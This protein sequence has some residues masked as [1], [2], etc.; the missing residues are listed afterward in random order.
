[1]TTPEGPAPGVGSPLG[2]P[3]DGSDPLDV[4]DSTTAG[5]RVIR[6]GILR[7]TTYAVGISIGIASAAL[8]TRYLG[9][10]DFGRY[11]IVTSLISIV[12]GLTEAGIP[13]VAAREFATRAPGDRDQ[14]FANVL[15]IRL[16]VAFAGVAAAIA[17]AIAAGYDRTMVAGTLLAGI[18]LLIATV[19]QTYAIPIGVSLRFGWLSSLDL[20]RQ[21]AFVAIIVVL[22]VASAGLLP[23]F[24]ATIPTSLLLLALMIPLVRGT[25]PLLP[26]F[27]RAEWVR[28]LRLVG[29][30]A[31]AAAVGTIYVSAVIVTT[32]LVGTAE[33]SGYLGAAFRV[34]SVLGAI[35]LLLI[36][37]AFPVLARAA[38]NDPE[39]LQYA[40]QRLIDI[41]LIVGS[42][43]ALSTVLGAGVAI[44][45]V[46]GEDFRSAV[47]VLQIL[48]AALLTTFLAVT[49]GLS[50]VSLRRHVALLVGNLVAL[51][52]SVA[53]TAAL[54]PEFGAKGAAVAT[55]VAD[56][57]IVVL[58][59]LVL[60]RV[61]SVRYDLELVPRVAIAAA[62]SGAVV[63]T[64]LDGVGLV[65]A[66]TV[67]YWGV[68]FAVR[69]VPSEVIDALL[70]REPRQTR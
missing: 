69:G 12:A 54:V 59:G 67:I 42:W 27:D 58:Y 34:F 15:G 21:I 22:V 35:P 41:S 11:V 26:R 47:P 64:P 4:L 18:G 65:L 62:L 61:R 36:S 10:E 37:T 16:A 50:L 33:E 57:G 56:C 70:R 1:L 40:I 51:T 5:S 55:L 45:V 6:G 53:L 9:V 3:V 24:A 60:F 48:G 2:G 29:V 14:L 17:F 20:V 28:I 19:Q 31:A 46:A 23:F 30:Y 49:G 63:L 13:N 52:A 43:L 39:R 7:V 32:S 66:A 68:L 44:N 25:A 8:M 38:H